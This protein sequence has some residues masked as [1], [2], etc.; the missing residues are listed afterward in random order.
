VN[1]DADA[2]Y[3]RALPAAWN[4][5]SRKVGGLRERL[6]TPLQRPVS[7]L[8]GAATGPF[9]P[10]GRMARPWSTHLMVWWTALLLGLVLLLTLL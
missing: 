4:A 6:R 9:R 8:W 10:N 7:V 5:L 3:R 1:L 2:V